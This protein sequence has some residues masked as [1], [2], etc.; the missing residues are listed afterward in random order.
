MKT[1][2]PYL[3]A[4]SLVGT[5]KAKNDFCNDITYLTL[6]DYTRN[7]NYG[8]DGKYQDVCDQTDCF[9]RPCFGTSID[10]HGSNWYRVISPAGSRITDT[11]VERNHCNTKYGG[12]I[13]GTHPTVLDEIVDRTVCFTNS[14]FGDCQDID[15]QEIQIRNCGEYYLYYLKETGFC[16]LRYCSE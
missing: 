16:D 12:W 1:H 5:L 7:R 9:L 3:I 11:Y 8:V 15:S 6:D 13:N 4:I 14:V 2:V 10:W